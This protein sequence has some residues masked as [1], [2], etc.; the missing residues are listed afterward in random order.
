[1]TDRHV[2]LYHMPHSR[3]TGV[4]T[5]LEELGADY[6]LEVLDIEKEE[7]RSE[8]YLAINPL[9]KVPAVVHRG[10]LITEQVALYV[11]LADLYADK[12]LAPSLDDPRRGPFLRWTAFY[13][14]S[15]EPA[16]IDRAE[17]RDPGPHARSP[18][19]TFDGV[20]DLLDEHLSSHEYFLGDQFM[21]LDVLWGSALRWTTG[22]GLVPKRA[23]FVD[24]I[25][26]VTSRPAF[27]RVAEI[28]GVPTPPTG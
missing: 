10:E 16:V 2:T 4:L 14:S 28:D 22:F 19:G 21:A 8:A 9:G 13:G 23:S 18:Y 12:G 25:E 26:R 27:A 11:F 6:Q 24:Y 1:M 3:S 17:E 7:Q 15:F 20:I 5:L